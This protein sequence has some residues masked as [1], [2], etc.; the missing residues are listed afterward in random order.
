MNPIADATIRASLV[1]LARLAL[2]PR[3]A[4]NR[5]RCGT[6]CWPPPSSRRRSSAF[7]GRGCPA[8]PVQADMAAGRPIRGRPPPMAPS[9]RASRRRRPP[10]EARRPVTEAR[11][12]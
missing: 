12:T 8:L 7:V 6:P 5:R 3:C 10:G 2:P 1:L 9:V 11:A 4:A